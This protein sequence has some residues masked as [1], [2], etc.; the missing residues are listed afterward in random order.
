MLWAIPAD[1]P[2]PGAPRSPSDP[3]KIK[4][5]PGSEP[6][7]HRRHRPSR[8]VGIVG[9]TQSGGDPVELIDPAD[10]RPLGAA[11][12]L[13]IAAEVLAPRKDLSAA[14]L[15]ERDLRIFR[16][17]RRDRFGD[18]LLELLQRR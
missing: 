7:A 4:G 18:S 12:E 10:P 3:P 17:W 6:D 5:A 11:E 8:S 15:G 14:M 2:G 13:G 9:Q 16:G 1:D